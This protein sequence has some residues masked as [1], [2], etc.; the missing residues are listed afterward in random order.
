MIAVL[1]A[2][3]VLMTVAVMFSV[4]PAAL[5]TVPTFHRPVPEAYVPWLEVAPTNVNPAGSRS[6]TRTPVAALGPAL[7]RVTVKAIWSPTLG[8][9][10]LTDFATI[11]SARCGVSVALAVLFAG[12]VSCA[13]EPPMVAVLVRVR[14]VSTR[15]RSR[16]LAEAP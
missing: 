14:E 7:E 9:G 16:R 8:V 3:A 12:L 11:R 4:A 15:A 13:P 2:A 10:L 6:A 5:A 1:V